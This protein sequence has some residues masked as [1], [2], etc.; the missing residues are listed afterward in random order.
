MHVQ[1]W[2]TWMGQVESVAEW[3][4]EDSGVNLVLFYLESP[5]DAIREFGPNSPEAQLAVHKVLH[6]I[7]F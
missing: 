3:L 7:L 4:A 6:Y 2:L 5:G 1:D